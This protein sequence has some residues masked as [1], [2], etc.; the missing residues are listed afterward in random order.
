MDLRP[1]AP[2][3]DVTMCAAVPR[4]SSFESGDHT[5]T[6]RFFSLSATPELHRQFL[7]LIG[8]AEDDPEDRLSPIE[9]QLR[10][11]R[12]AGLTQVDCLWRWRGFALMAGWSG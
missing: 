12:Q 3:L 5:R 11:M 4:R 9:D 10:W 7:N 1:S 2:S 8:R 6:R